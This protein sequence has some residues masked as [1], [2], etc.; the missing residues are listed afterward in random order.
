MSVL[1]K[2]NE[3]DGDEWRLT[4]FLTYNI[5]K[6]IYLPILD[7]KPRKTSALPVFMVWKYFPR[8]IELLSSRQ[9]ERL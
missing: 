1:T 7:K 5:L 6:Y 2:T 8:A 4:F 9:K 3:K